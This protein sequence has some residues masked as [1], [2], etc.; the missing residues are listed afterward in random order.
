MCALCFGVGVLV[1]ARPAHAHMGPSIAL[2]DDDVV[3]GASLGACGLEDARGVFCPG[4]ALTYA[5]LAL[6][7]T[8]TWRTLEVSGERLHVVSAEAG[9]WFYVSLSAGVGVVLADEPRPAVHGALSFTWPFDLDWLRGARDDSDGWS[10]THPAIEP[11]Y[12]L[13]YVVGPQGSL[14]H[15]LGLALELSTED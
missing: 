14:M 3:V 2:P 13:S 5:N 1:S 8:A 15:E 11:Y 4:A 10:L 12:R 6:T 9:L 7:L